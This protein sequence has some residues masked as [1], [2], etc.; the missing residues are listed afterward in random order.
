MALKPILFRYYVLLVVVG[1]ALAICVGNLR[2]WTS[3]PEVV[4]SIVAI[5]LGFIYFVQRQ[6][7]DETRLFHEL[8]C[9]FN[10]RYDKLNARLMRMASKSELDERDRAVAIDYFNLCAEEYLFYR[11]GYILPDVW[12]SWCRGMWQYVG[13]ESP[14]RRLW[15]EEVAT[16][17][18]YGLTLKEIERSAKLSLIGT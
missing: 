18:Y 11:E 2:G 12:T 1:S 9:A 16:G 10:N 8:F 17:S 4:V 7:L 13:A 14:L 15:I 6:K 3:K 5:S